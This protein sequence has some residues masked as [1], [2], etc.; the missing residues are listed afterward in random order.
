MP[1][2][3]LLEKLKSSGLNE[4][5]LKWVF[6]YLYQREQFVV[7][8][9]K[10]SATKPVL[11]GVPQ[12]SV[13]GP[14][15][16]LVYINDCVCEP[17][18]NDSH[19]TL[20]A[21]D[22]LLYRVINSPVDYTILQKDVDTLSSWVHKNNLTLNALKCKF[23]VMSRLRT[24]SVPVPS[25]TLNEQPLE[26]VSSYKYL[27][28]NITENLLWSAH[29]EEISSKARQIIGLMY[30]QFYTWSSPQALLQLYMSLVRPHLEYAAQVWNPHL[31]KDINRLEQVQKF[32]LKICYKEWSSTYPE[33]LEVSALPELS[34]RRKCLNLCYFYKLVNNSF[35]F[36]N[37]PLSV[38]TLN[39]PNRNGRTSLYVQPY[40]NSNA[41]L[42]SFFPSTIS[43]WNSLPFA[44]VSAISLF[45]FKSQ[46]SQLVN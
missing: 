21:D 39:Y 34:V 17:L 23:M 10:K 20:Y 24:K 46:L 25:L 30:R 43:L 19:T 1:H 38:R 45:S 22:M 2:R 28:V 14:L 6:S 7:L 44:A 8:N 12:G 11:S 15:L 18:D 33:L 9:G 31:I 37:C 32:A 35:E 36:P 42:N 5:I 16:F 4:H 41:F 29:I 40:A 3:S 27:G 13:L 26:R